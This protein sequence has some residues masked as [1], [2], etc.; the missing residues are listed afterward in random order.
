MRCLTA[1][2]AS[3]GAPLPSNKKASAAWATTWSR[4]TPATRVYPGLGY[5]RDREI[6]GPRYADPGIHRTRVSPGPGYT[7]DPEGC[8][9][10]LGPLL[11]IAGAHEN[12][13][14]LR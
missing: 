8:L 9:E 11:T 12:S 3:S 7:R 14:E 1:R 13:C 5:T 4:H 2:A 10:N 6:P